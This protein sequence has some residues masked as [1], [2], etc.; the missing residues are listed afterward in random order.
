MNDA[1][2]P[3]YF[4]EP[5]SAAGGFVA[6]E[7]GGVFVALDV[8]GAAELAAAGVA[9]PC[10]SSACFAFARLKSSSMS[11]LEPGVPFAPRIVL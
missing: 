4:F 10:L 5:A 9:T 2:M 3:R 1:S 6:V 7:V 8:A 11:S